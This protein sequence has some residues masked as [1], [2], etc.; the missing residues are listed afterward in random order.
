MGGGGNEGPNV[1]LAVPPPPWPA[2]SS[3]AR[4]VRAGP[5]AL[6]LLSPGM[7]V[8]AHHALWPLQDPF[9]HVI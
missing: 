9:L 4:A 2:P 1:R 6:S 7:Q 3:E 5:G 8:C